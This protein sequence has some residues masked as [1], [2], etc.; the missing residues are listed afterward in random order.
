MVIM[1][2]GATLFLGALMVVILCVAAS[3]FSIRPDTAWNYYHF[4]GHGFSA[5][6]PAAGTP[7]L[8]LRDGVLPVVLSRPTKV[9]SVA[10]PADKGVIAG[11]CFIQS[12]GGRLTE[13]LGYA[14]C[15]RTPVTIS[16]GST[17]VTKVDSD[18]NGYFVV[19]LPA[20]SYRVSSGVF[21]V[22]SKVVKGTTKLVPL[23]A[24]KRMVD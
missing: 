9:E 13:G 18:E 20:G 3:A 17:V 23:R 6:Q 19:V 5:G 22:E 14:P 1:S 8:A 15:P 24:G 10:L 4:D 16:S 11:I 2:N 7:F 21:G 12:S